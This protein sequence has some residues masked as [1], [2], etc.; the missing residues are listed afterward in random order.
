MQRTIYLHRCPVNSVK[1]KPPNTV[2]GMQV[3]ERYGGGREVGERER[4][5][6]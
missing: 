1:K 4:V 5:S 2:D 3:N 6:R